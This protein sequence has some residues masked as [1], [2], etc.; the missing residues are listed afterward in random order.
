M[1]HFLPGYS[2]Y[3]LPDKS[4]NSALTSD[5]FP[6]FSLCSLA[7]ANVK[8]KMRGVGR[9]GRSHGVGGMVA[10]AGLRALCEKI[11]K[12]TLTLAKQFSK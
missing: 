4:V 2:Q 9:E 10:R 12:Y 1:I 5:F 6:E 7:F 11:H 3:E 8:E